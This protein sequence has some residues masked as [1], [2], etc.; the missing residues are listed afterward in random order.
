LLLLTGDTCTKSAKTAKIIKATKA[1]KLAL[2]RRNRD[3]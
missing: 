1:E 3:G 2:G